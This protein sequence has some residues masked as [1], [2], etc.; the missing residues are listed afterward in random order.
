MIL[1]D[2]RDYLRTRKQATLADIAL[3]VEADPDAVRGM[4]QR[5]LAKGQVTRNTVS[6]GCGTS[7]S[8]CDPAAREL[9]FWVENG[10]AD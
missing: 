9:Y 3:H 8:K 5:L 10:A 1:T 2:I 6:S 4:L 7:C